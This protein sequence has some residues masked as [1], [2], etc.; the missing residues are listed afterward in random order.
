MNR[1][2]IEDVLFAMGIPANCKGF[3]YISDAMEVIEKEGCDVS[4]TKVLYPAI[5]KKNKTTSSRVERAIRYAFELAYN[6]N[7]NREIM[8]KYIGLNRTNSSSLASIYRRINKEEESDVE[9]VEEQIS[10]ISPELDSAIRK[11]IREELKRIVSG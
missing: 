6:G 1:N 11:I 8:D 2:K 9:E 5:A 7:E 10:E 4:A 3:D